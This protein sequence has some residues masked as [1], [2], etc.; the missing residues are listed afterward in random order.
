MTFC[1]KCGHLISDDSMYC[2]K[3]GT[4]KEVIQSEVVNA[5]PIQQTQQPTK[6]VSRR[7]E[8]VVFKVFSIVALVLGIV[9]LAM[10]SLGFLNIFNFFIIGY[11]LGAFAISF[12]VPGIIFGAISKKRTYIS[13]GKAVTGFILSLIGTIIGTIV[14]IIAFIQLLES[15][16]Y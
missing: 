14:F 12:G 5:E 8:P 4:V 1:K 11:L 3:C 9:S 6:L 16:I 2:P 7:G 13:H 15:T 10:A